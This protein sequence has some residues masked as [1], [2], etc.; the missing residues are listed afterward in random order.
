M[1]RTVPPEEQASF[2]A[3]LGSSPLSNSPHAEEMIIAWN[4]SR[5]LGIPPTNCIRALRGQKGQDRFIARV[6]GAVAAD[7][8]I[9]FVQEGRVRRTAFASP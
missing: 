2:E 9:V 6:E 8:T 5:T 1:S 4:L 7:P 3:W